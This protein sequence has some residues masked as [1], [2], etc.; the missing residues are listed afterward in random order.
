MRFF[1][2]NIPNG[3]GVDNLPIHYKWNT[4]SEHK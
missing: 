3:E 1:S 2:N 4:W